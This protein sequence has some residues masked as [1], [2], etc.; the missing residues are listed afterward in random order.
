MTEIQFTPERRRGEQQA[1]FGRG[2][3]K[4]TGMPGGIRRQMMTPNEM[5]A[6]KLNQALAKVAENFTADARQQAQNEFVDMPALRTMNMKV[7]AVTLSFL[8]DIVNP[9]PQNF[10]DEVIL[11]YIERLLPEKL[12]PQDRQRLILRFKAQILIYIKAIA[13]YREDE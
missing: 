11:P 8:H 7:L 9:T 3:G 12:N 10:R 6:W 13:L 5:A 4:M 2:G 1:R